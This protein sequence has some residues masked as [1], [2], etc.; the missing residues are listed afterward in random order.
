MMMKTEQKRYIDWNGMILFPNLVNFLPFLLSPLLVTGWITGF[1][2][3]SS[4][5]HLRSASLH[6]ILHAQVFSSFFSLRSFICFG[7][8]PFLRMPAHRFFF[9]YS[10]K[11]L[12]FPIS[13]GFNSLEHATNTL[14]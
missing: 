6:I 3:F 4:S 10:F 13:F 14:R 12:V 5:T 11:F 8:F 2:S 9:Y 7:F 1:L